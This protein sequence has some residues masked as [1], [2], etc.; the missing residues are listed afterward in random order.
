MLR[1]WKGLALFR[2]WKWLPLLGVLALTVVLAWQLGE[3]DSDATPA[4]P[5]L[6]KPLAHFVAQPLVTLLPAGAEW[7]FGA[8]VFAGDS[9]DSQVDSLQLFR[10][11]DFADAQVLVVNVFASW[12]VPCLAEHPFLQGLAAQGVPII[13]MAWNDM[14]RDTARWLQRHGNPYRAVISDQ[15]SAVGVEFGVSGVPETFVVRLTS[16]GAVLIWHHVG[17]LTPDVVSGKL[18]PLLDNENVTF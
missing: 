13:G 18:L 14:P 9:S 6:G 15:G 10:R 2:H 12:C 1:A 17:I 3:S 5:L 16:D 7:D 8:D 11:A 4:H